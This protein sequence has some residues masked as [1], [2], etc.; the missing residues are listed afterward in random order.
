MK[1]LKSDLKGLIVRGVDAG[2]S[3]EE[4]GSIFDKQW[5]K[6]LDKRQTAMFYPSDWEY[7]SSEES[8]E[9]AAEEES[10]EESEEAAEDPSE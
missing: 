5:Q 1:Q 4:I 8:S 10:E 9:E 7:E 3:F 2:F 6:E